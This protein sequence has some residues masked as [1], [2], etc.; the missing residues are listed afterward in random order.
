MRDKERIRNFY[1]FKATKE[2]IA[3]W[4]SVLDSGTRK[5]H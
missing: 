2:I 5:G 3:T 1:K 4:D